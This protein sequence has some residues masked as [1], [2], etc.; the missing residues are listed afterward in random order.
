M[1]L[2]GLVGKKQVGKDTVARWL[3]D[4]HQF[5]QYAFATPIKAACKIL[6]LLSDEQLHASH[7]KEVVVPSWGLSPRQMFQLLGTDMIRKHYRDDFWI[8]HFRLWYE[9]HSMGDVVV[10]DVRFQN[11]ADTIKDLGGILIKIERRTRHIDHHASE[12]QIITGCDYVIENNGP[13]AD[14]FESV[15]RIIESAK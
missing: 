15:E 1:V 2:I 9:T 13:V 8:H 12:Q 6:F 4:Q 7:H 5:S 10:S 11:E 14:L 3:V